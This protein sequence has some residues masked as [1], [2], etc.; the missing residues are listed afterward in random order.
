MCF[1]SAG[2]AC[3][4]MLKLPMGLFQVQD[5]PGFGIETVVG[6]DEVDSGGEVGGSR[7]TERPA[8]GSARVQKG[9]FAA[10]KIIQPNFKI[11]SGHAVQFN[12]KPA[13]ERIGIDA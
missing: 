4:S 11:S 5:L 10:Q 9:N 6:R 2:F 1:L 3:Y 7:E 13:V 12:S 8:Q